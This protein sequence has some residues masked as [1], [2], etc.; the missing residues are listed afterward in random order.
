MAPGSCYLSSVCCAIC[1]SPKLVPTVQFFFFFPAFFCLFPYMRVKSV[2]REYMSLLELYYPLPT[3]LPISFSLF[4][5]LSLFGP[6]FPLHH[7]SFP[8]YLFTHPP[9]H[10]PNF[11]IAYLPFPPPPSPNVTYITLPPS[12]A[13]TNHE[14]LIL[15]LF[16]F[17]SYLHKPYFSRSAT[18]SPLSPQILPRQYSY[19]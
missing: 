6:Y 7:H 4:I 17:L 15:S 8:M 11:L 18:C 12:T 16:T 2:R 13:S 9:T 10:L 19:T 3:L 14:L 5:Y 1:L